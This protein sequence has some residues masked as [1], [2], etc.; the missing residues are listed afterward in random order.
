MLIGGFIYLVYPFTVG[1]TKMQSF[2]ET[3]QIGELEENVMARA[4]DQGYTRRELENGR[5]LLINS[6]A[7]GRFI[8]DVSISDGKIAGVTYVHND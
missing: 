5:L 3:I 4:D 7:M 1:G 6:R 8:C 2:C